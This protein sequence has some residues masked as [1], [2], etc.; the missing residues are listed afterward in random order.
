MFQVFF[1]FFPFPS[2]FLSSPF[3]SSSLPWVYSLNLTCSRLSLL[4][5]WSIL[6]SMEFEVLVPVFSAVY[7]CLGFLLHFPHLLF[8]LWEGKSG[9]ST[10]LP[11]PKFF[12]VLSHTNDCTKAD[13]WIWVSPKASAHLQ[14]C[15]FRESLLHMQQIF[16]KSSHLNLSFV[17][18]SLFSLFSMGRFTLII[19][20]CLRPTDIQWN[21]ALLLNLLSFYCLERYT[22]HNTSSDP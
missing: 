22:T 15:V 20:E 18:I 6:P 12:R 2:D 16:F 13:S 7:I 8:L 4:S 11:L 17:C 21:L 5:L 10:A 19:W 3:P 14:R 1:S 9:L